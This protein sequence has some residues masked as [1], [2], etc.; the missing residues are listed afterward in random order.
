MKKIILI[1]NTNEVYEL[2]KQKKKY[3]QLI[4]IDYRAAILCHIKKIKFL[5]IKDI[6]NNKNS[7]KLSNQLYS[8]YKIATKIDKYIRKK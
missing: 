8:A 4:V 1:N 2:L 3:S 5:Y 7:E 6:Y